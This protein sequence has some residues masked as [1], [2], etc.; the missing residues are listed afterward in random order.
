M[1]PNDVSQR[2][3]GASAH[4]RRGPGGVEDDRLVLPAAEDLAATDV[5]QNKEAAPLAGQLGLRE[6]EHGPPGVAGLRG[7]T[8]DDGA[9]TG[10]ITGDL[11]PQGAALPARGGGGA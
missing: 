10:S 7:E 5:V 4:R 11:R 6:L 9:G 1:V 3:L 2:G 8:N